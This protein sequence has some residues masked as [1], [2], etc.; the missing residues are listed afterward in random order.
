[1]K[2]VSIKWKIFLY[3]IGFCSLLL[4][5]LWFF[6]VIFLNDFYKNIK[7]GEVKRTAQ[8]IMNSIDSEELTDLVQKY[9]FMNDVC[10][11]ILIEGENYPITSDVLGDCVI[12]KM[13]ALEKIKMLEKTQE[14]NGE[15]LEYFSLY[16][17]R[18]KTTS[19]RPMDDAKLEIVYSKIL[20]N[21]ENKMVIIFINSVANPVGATVSTLRAQLY[22]I[23][24]FMVAI[25]TILA[26]LISKYISKPIEELNKSTKRLAS[27]KYD[28]AFSG[29]GYKEIKELSDTLNYT[30]LELS[31]V[32]NLRKE[33]IANVS[34]DLRTP[35]TLIAGYAEAMRDLPEENNAENAQIIVDET[36]RLT[37]LVNDTL[38]LSKLQSGMQVLALSEFNLTES[39]KNGI[40]RMQEF[41][42]K[43]GYQIE[44]DH[45][46]DVMICADETK[47][48][49]VFYNLLINAISYT[50]EDHR[51]IIHQIVEED[52]V[53]IEVT[54]SG[55]G[56]S[57]ENLPYIWD[58]Y[59]K[60]D[61]NH[62]RPITGTG[63]GLSIV[64]S[65]MGLHQ[66][67]YGVSS[68]VGKGSTFWFSLKR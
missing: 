68:Q 65:I 61:E 1:M 55:E 26:I 22:Y 23:T 54:D 52:L 39:L 41:I 42:K 34:H 18:T 16:T 17:I 43:E 58:R 40:D 60:I 44:F 48:S 49:R 13:T 4:V 46:T 3:L 8:L 24:F 33:L 14:N 56:I 51:V 67:G 6:Q 19:R 45:D 12:H 21:K 59:Y 7:I 66:G 35:L 20:H 36:K 28:T 9:S 53:K 25:S 64:K 15:M 37:S 62:K 27:G 50:G 63:I 57:E 31:K 30:A 47:I 32:E 38:D 29:N 11:E 2:N 5:F 10:I